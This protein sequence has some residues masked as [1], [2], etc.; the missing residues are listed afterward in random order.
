VVFEQKTVMEKRQKFSRQ[1]GKASLR[2]CFSVS[3]KEL[4]NE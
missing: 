3:D 1:F 4:E 2:R